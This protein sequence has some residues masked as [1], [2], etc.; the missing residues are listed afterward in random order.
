MYHNKIDM[1]S[2]LF[3]ESW[4]EKLQPY[5]GLI[6]LGL[7][8]FSRHPYDR[9]KL[10]LRKQGTLQVIYQDIYLLTLCSLP[11][12]VDEFCYCHENR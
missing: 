8:T 5:R 10:T 7:G 6:K 12:L 4:M 11:Q 2:N 3:L 1:L 9:L